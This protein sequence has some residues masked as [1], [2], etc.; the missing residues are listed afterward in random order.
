MNTLFYLLR[1]VAGAHGILVKIIMSLGSCP[2]LSYIL[3]I[4][5][6]LFKGSF[7]KVLVWLYFVRAANGIICERIMYSFY[8]ECFAPSP[9]W[10]TTGWLKC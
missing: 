10:I 5:F 8:R 9:G 2:D 4:D 1:D 3:R 7:L 6:F